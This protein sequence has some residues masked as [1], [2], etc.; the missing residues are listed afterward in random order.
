M[1]PVARRTLA[2]QRADSDHVGVVAG[3][4]DGLRRWP[5][6]AGRSHDHD[7]SRPRL[8]SGAVQWVHEVGCSGV[9]T[10]AHVQ[11]ADVEFGSVVHHVL[12]ALDDVRIR[13]GAVVSQHADTEH[14]GVRSDA[15]RYLGG[16][17]A[18]LVPDDTSYVCAVAKA[19]L[20]VLPCREAVVVIL[21]PEHIGLFLIAIGLADRVHEVRLAQE[22]LLD[23][24]T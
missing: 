20:A 8:F 5:R 17:I 15:H 14:I 23:M 3:D 13:A 18:E 21:R 9:G 12:D 1:G 6:I 22:L 10:Q 4:S 19:I 11:D 16:V 7:A 2:V 24:R